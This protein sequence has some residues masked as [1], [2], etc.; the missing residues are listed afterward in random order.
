MVKNSPI[1]NKV[2]KALLSLFE[3]EQLNCGWNSVVIRLKGITET[4][5][6]RNLTTHKISVAAYRLYVTCLSRRGLR[7]RISSRLQQ[8]SF[9]SLTVKRLSCKEESEFKS[10]VRSNS[11]YHTSRE[12]LKCPR[13]S[14]LGEVVKGVRHLGWYWIN[15]NREKSSIR[16]NPTTFHTSVA[17]LV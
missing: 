8:K 7:V 15:N 5:L 14:L 11:T 12:V 6:S 10:H 16:S 17:Q 4:W 9:G 13:I 1:E 3:K 2:W